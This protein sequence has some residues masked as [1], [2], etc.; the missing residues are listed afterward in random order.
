MR[1]SITKSA[2]SRCTCVKVEYQDDAEG[3]K[4]QS[5]MYDE[6]LQ[7]AD[8]SSRL[9]ISVSQTDLATSTSGRLERA[10]KCKVTAFVPSIRL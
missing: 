5:A 7:L 1:F 8:Q 9:I 3:R 10:S 4:A 6:G 2:D